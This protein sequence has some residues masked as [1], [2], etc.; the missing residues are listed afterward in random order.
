[1]AAENKKQVDYVPGTPCAQIS[2]MGIWIVQA[3][4]WGNTWAGRTLSS[5]TAK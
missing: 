2:K 1:M 3:H 4:E 5:V